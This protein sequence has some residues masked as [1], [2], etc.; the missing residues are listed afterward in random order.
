M[1]SICII[2]FLFYNFIC[3]SELTD[4]YV[5]A[6]TEGDP[7][8]NVS[9]SVNIFTG[10]FTVFSQ[11]AIVSGV[12]PIAIKR[13]YVSGDG[14]GF[15]SNWVFFPHLQLTLIEGNKHKKYQRLIVAEP[16][17]SVLVYK[18]QNIKH[19]WP[20]YKIDFKKHA[21]GITNTAKGILSA[22]TNLKN[23]TLYLT[24]SD[25]IKMVTAAGGERWYTK[26]IIERLH[27]A[28]HFLLRYERLPN[29]QFFTYEYDKYD[30]VKAIYSM[31]PHRNKIWAWC[32]MHYHGKPEE[33]HDFDIHTSDGKKLAYRF[34]KLTGEKT[35]HWILDEMHS[36]ETGSEHEEYHA[37]Q[38][39]IGPLV[40]TRLFANGRKI[41]ATYYEPQ[42]IN[43]VG[44]ASVKIK[45]RDVDNRCDK[46]STLFYPMGEGGA[47][48]HAYS[49][50]YNQNREK[51]KRHKY[52]YTSGDTEVVDSQ[53]CKKK[54]LFSPDF[55][56]CR[57]EHYDEQSRLHHVT[58]TLWGGHGE[59]AQ[60]SYQTASGQAILLKN[61][62]YDFKG[63]VIE[64]QTVGDLSGKGAQER[65]CKRF[66]YNEQNLLIHQEEDSGLIVDFTYL[67]GTD[68]PISKIVSNKQ[69]ILV[70]EFCEYNEDHLLIKKIRDDGKEREP[71]NLYGVTQRN[72]E[73]IIPKLSEPGI[74]MPEIIEERSFTLDHPEGQLLQKTKLHY[75]PACQVIQKDLFDA[76][77]TLRYSLHFAYDGMGRLIEERDALG[78][79]T[80]YLYD[81]NGNKI[82]EELP[83][84]KKINYTYDALNR[85]T[86]EEAEGKREKND[87]S[88]MSMTAKADASKR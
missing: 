55:L 47:L 29:G 28:R 9:D 3:F 12:E 23:Q 61:Y 6:V 30:R 40:K 15:N 63:N 45:E 46:V 35:I 53:G 85:L 26:T 22:R 7:T 74:G 81:A 73:I 62:L 24:K 59:I 71:S 38:S 86:S 76:D 54:V 10:D 65:Y 79:I 42:S 64:E 17:G 48:K 14:N 50:F 72:L 36:S 31:N 2:F 34:K 82:Y 52:R 43:K 56:P 70:R 44:E 87:S 37:A 58:E 83:G 33:N 25:T 68:L 8:E 11:D 77:G 66:A 39:E 32:T 84:G 69:E 41:Q 49:F 20:T 1:R 13:F 67:P 5:H 51:I 21:K 27:R 75:S 88:S 18:N 60:K 78:Q 80:K 16:N 19:Q 4:A 57:V